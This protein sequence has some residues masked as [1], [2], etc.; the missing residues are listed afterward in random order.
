MMTSDHHRSS[1]NGMIRTVEWDMLDK[2][3]FFPMSM[4]SSFTVRCCLYPLTLIRTRLQ[5]QYQSNEYSGTWDAGRK[6]VRTEGVRGL[7]RG[8]FVS[9]FQVVSGLFYVSTYES[10]RHFLDTNNITQNSKVKAFIGGGCGS[11]VGQ[12][13]IVPFDVISQHMMLIKSDQ[14][15]SFGRNKAPAAAAAT[16]GSA[17][18]AAAPCQAATVSVHNPL[19]IQTE[20]RT[21]SQIAR[22]ITRAIYRQDGI[23]GFYRG[24]TASLATYVPSSASW[25]A[26]YH[27]FQE[28][29]YTV[30]P[31]A[32]AGGDSQS[33]RGSHTAVQCMAAMSSGCATCVITNPLDLTRARVQVQR[34][35]IPETLKTLW[36]EEGLRMFAK[37]L[38]A[39]MTAS[40]IYSVAIIFGYESVKKMT[41]LDEYKD[42]V[43]W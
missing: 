18:V 23:R 5:I 19:G 39:R 41:V 12:T 7:Y 32:A 29:L 11:I 37:G 2:A 28:C 34:K 36:R 43:A 30:V 20:N 31:A 40:V 24:Y 13:C 10:V 22:D 21:R 35:S 42:R 4:A 26:F 14:R 38:T 17:G 33:S 8:F 1:S 16:A 25:W 15:T 9:A 6:I 3:K 27:F